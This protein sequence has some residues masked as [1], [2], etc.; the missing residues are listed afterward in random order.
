MIQDHH[1]RANGIRL[2]DNEHSFPI[3][4]ESL[5]LLIKLLGFFPT[6]KEKSSFFF[7]FRE[8]QIEILVSN[9]LMN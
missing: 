4:A 1:N 8:C 5:N 3:Q 7:L 6:M 9:S 2:V